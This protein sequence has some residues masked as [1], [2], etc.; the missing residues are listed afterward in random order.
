MPE[1]QLALDEAKIRFTRMPRRPDVRIRAI[2][3]GGLS[4]SWAC[5]TA[6]PIPGVPTM[7]SELIARIRAT[8][9]ARRMPVIRYGRSVGKTRCRT[10]WSHVIRSVRTVSSA[11]LSMSVMPYMTWIMTI[12][13]QP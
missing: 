3:A 13:K 2:I 10:R 12:Q 11:T 7:S 9:A 1:E 4:F 8:V 5:A 6:R